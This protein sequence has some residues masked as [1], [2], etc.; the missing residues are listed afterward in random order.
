MSIVYISVGILCRYSVDICSIN[1]TNWYKLHLSGV[2]CAWPFTEA[3]GRLWRV[4]SFRQSLPET[5]AGRGFEG[6]Q[7]YPAPV[8][9]SW[10]NDVKWCTSKMGVHDGSCDNTLH[11]QA[12]E[13]WSSHGARSEAKTKRWSDL[14]GRSLKPKLESGYRGAL[15]HAIES[16][17][18]KLLSLD[19]MILWSELKALRWWNQ[20]ILSLL[21]WC[22]GAQE[23]LQ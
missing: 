8:A 11:E 1:T 12:P 13:I 16:I 2:A 20:F 19:S 17:S 4:H 22:V 7:R 3:E 14:F 9:E 18:R 5:M 21:I 6:D 23:K 10:Q 15:F